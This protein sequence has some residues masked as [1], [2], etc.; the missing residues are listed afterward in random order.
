MNIQELELLLKKFPK[1]NLCDYNTP[2]QR[3]SNYEERLGFN[4]I[5]I[6][7]DDL[8]G[9]GSGG[10]KIRNLE[11]LLGDAKDKGA[12][13]IIASGQKESNLCSL[14]ASA[15]AKLKMKCVLVHNSN[16]SCGDSGNMR[17]NEI[18][19]VERVFLGPISEANRD[20]YTKILAEDYRAKGKKVYIIENG[21]TSTIGAL[22]YVDACTE[23]ARQRERYKFNDICVCGGNGGLATGLIFGSA[24]LDIPFHIN[25]ITVENEKERLVE[26]IQDLIKKLEKHTGVKFPYPLDKVMTIYD[27]YRGGGWGKSTKES[28]DII[29]D[30]AQTEGIFLESVYVSKTMYGMLDLCKKGVFKNGVC[31]IH[32]G[33]FSSIF[34]QRF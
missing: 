29:Y 21:A 1:V 4:N 7:R 25:V 22:G 15:C 14:T 2:I 8:N 13:I 23:L 28:I 30:F 19:D 32:S 6:K 18:L 31:G 9:V 10:N 12:D 20:R 5:F 33:G 27:E 11:Y 3:L 17:L 34:S 16:K 24:L 26:I